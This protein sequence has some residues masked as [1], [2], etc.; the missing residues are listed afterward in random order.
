MFS[1]AA[2]VV[3]DRVLAG[4]L[5]CSS[6]SAALLTLYKM[7]CDEYYSAMRG[8]ALKE[9]MGTSFVAQMLRSEMAL[10]GC[11][12]QFIKQRRKEKKRPIVF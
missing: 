11:V 8:T 12:D 6:S 5:E 2:W 9:H 4:S 3:L 10:D 7:L 1:H